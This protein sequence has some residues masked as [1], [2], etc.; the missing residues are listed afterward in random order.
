[1][2]TAPNGFQ[3]PKI[4]WNSANVPL[5]ADFNRIEGNINSIET[6]N[7]TVD[8]TQT[9]TGNTG[10]LRQFLDW[11]SNRIKTL[12]GTTNWWDTITESLSAVA[13]RLTSHQNAA[14]PHSGHETP[15]GAQA[16]VDSHAASTQTHGASG[17][18]RLAKTSR[19]DQLPAWADIP[20]KP[21]SFTPS[22]HK[23]T[24]ASGGSDALTPSDIGAETPSGAQAK[25][26]AHANR[27]D[28]PHATT[29]GQIGA[30]AKTGDTMT[31]ALQFNDSNTK[32]LEGSS[33]AVR[34]QTNSG[35]ID[36]G[37]QNTSYGHIYTDRASFYFNKDL[38]VN[39]NKV[40]HAGNDGAGS[41]L[42]ADK[43][44][45]FDI[46]QMTYYMTVSDTVLLEALTERSFTNCYFTTPA[47]AKQFSMWLPGSYR[48][49]GE[50]RSGTSG[51]TV[52]VEVSDKTF[53]TTS[54]SYVA[55]SFDVG[56]FSS[57]SVGL[58]VYVSTSGTSAVVY[59]RNVRVKG[60]PGYRPSHTVVLN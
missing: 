12:A 22:A 14:A 4:D 34:V 43:I 31:G 55:F 41:G 1:M 49:T 25:V 16:K 56:P 7:R 18:Y 5:P 21:S 8:P 35:Y 51:A 58:S 6:G 42:D 47:L 53:S 2:S 52:K 46:S 30:V 20:D 60:S 28:N 36:I 27:T 23:S 50:L 40:W 9:P 3:N 59:I 45:G 24:H 15:A 48:V 32:L 11:F 37:P 13:Q 57:N 19:T 29:A 17:S 38:L 33:N 10:T 26:D 44:D 54:T 39:G